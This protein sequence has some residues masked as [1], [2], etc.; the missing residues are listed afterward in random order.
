MSEFYN[1]KNKAQ[2]FWFEDGY[3]V[4][5]PSYPASCMLL[6]LYRHRHDDFSQ[7]NESKY[8]FSFVFLSIHLIMSL[9]NNYNWS[10][11]NFSGSNIFLFQ[12]NS[13]ITCHFKVFAFFST[14]ALVSNSCSE[15]VLFDW[16]FQNYWRVKSEMIN[17]LQFLRFRT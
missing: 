9:I 8:L 13:V 5:F 10:Q 4:F 11:V 12:E 1:W 3:Y 6:A 17:I 7:H 16:L 2:S 14:S 15:I